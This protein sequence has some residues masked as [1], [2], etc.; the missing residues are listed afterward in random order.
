MKN[1]VS[2]RDFL[3]ASAAAMTAVGRS[4]A[5]EPAAP[6]ASGPTRGIRIRFLGS[7][8]SGWRPEWGR[9]SPHMR[10]Q[11]SVLLENRALIDF[12]AC[13]FDKLPEVSLT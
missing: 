13:S 7:G 12:T 5:D 2:R 1:N 6:A 4:F 10:R 3:I 9:K 11:S 8:A